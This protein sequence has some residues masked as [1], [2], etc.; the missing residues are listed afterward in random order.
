MSGLICIST[1]CDIL[2][3]EQVKDNMYNGY[4]TALSTVY[5]FFGLWMSFYMYGR[6]ITRYVEE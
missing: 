2:M 6:K 5:T 4:L 3:E 1:L